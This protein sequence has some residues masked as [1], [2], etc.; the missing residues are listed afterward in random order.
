M[1]ETKKRLAAASHR[2]IY[3]K[4]DAAWRLGLAA[5]KANVEDCPLRTK[6]LSAGNQPV[7]AYAVVNLQTGGEPAT[8]QRSH[9]LQALAALRGMRASLGY[10]AHTPEPH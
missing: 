2:P 1:Q 5:R 9:L 3:L 6:V 8:T 7:G 10:S 4:S